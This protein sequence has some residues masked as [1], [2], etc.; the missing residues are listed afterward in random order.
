[1][2]QNPLKSK[3]LILCWFIVGFTFAIGHM[4]VAFMVS[5]AFYLLLG[6]MRPGAE[7]ELILLAS[8]LGG[9]AIV[10]VFVIFTNIIPYSVDRL[11]EPV[12]VAGVAL[13]LLFT[14]LKALAWILIAYLSFM[15]TLIFDDL[16]VKHVSIHTQRADIAAIIRHAILLFCLFLWFRRKA[17][18]MD[19]TGHLE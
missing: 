10:S 13:A 17:G 11:W 18:A 14:R 6:L 1:M 3:A 2:T 12:V 7:P 9:Q 8:E 4:R 15:A 19:K 16:F 5:L